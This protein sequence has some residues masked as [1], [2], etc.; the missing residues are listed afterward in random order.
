MKFKRKGMFK[1][2]VHIFYDLWDHE[3][4]YLWDQ[5]FE[6]YIFAH[7]G[8]WGSGANMNG[9]ILRD[10]A[11]DLPKIGFAKHLAKIQEKLPEGGWIQI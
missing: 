9:R 6:E 5:E 3:G 10:H 7:P 8:W 4:N 1:R 11:V 2:C